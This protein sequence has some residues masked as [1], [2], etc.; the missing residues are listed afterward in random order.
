MLMGARETQLNTIHIFYCSYQN[1]HLLRRSSFES[2]T[3]SVCACREPLI[4]QRRTWNA[5]LL[6]FHNWRLT[7]N[8]HWDWR[9]FRRWTFQIETSKGLLTDAASRLSERAWTCQRQEKKTCL[10]SRFHCTIE[11]HQRVDLIYWLKFRH[12]RKLIFLETLCDLNDLEWR[13]MCAW[14]LRSKGKSGSFVFS[15]TSFP[16]LPSWLMFRSSHRFYGDRNLNL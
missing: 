7:R 11:H 4:I 14:S 12:L 2:L 5:F 10:M 9:N 8:V 15:K 6:R 1:S 16:F 13:F 3:N